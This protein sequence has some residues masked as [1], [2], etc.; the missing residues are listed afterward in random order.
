MKVYTKAPAEVERR[1]AALREKHYEEELEHVTIGAL[2]V[3]DDE[4]PELPVLSHQGY[5]ASALIRVVGLRDRAQGMPD[6]QMVID[7]CTYLQ[8][9]AKKQS[10]LLDH[11]L[12][13]L[14]RKLDKHGT[15]LFDALDRPKLTTR[16][17]D[18]QL[19]WFDEIA[20]RHGRDSV[21][22]MQARRL[23]EQSGQLYFDF[24]PET[25]AA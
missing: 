1:I 5:P 21:E 7:R 2:F 10:A 13:H 14:V 15:P 25:K 8:I 22:V 6:A 4:K 24:A 18:W 12:Y 11:E 16:K 20:N 9:D 23:L 3:H 19:G 17:H